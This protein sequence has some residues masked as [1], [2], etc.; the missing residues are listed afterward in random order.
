MDTS[1]TKADDW[2]HTK[3]AWLGIR[4]C[5]YTVGLS[6]LLKGRW[7]Q[8]SL[9]AEHGSRTTLCNDLLARQACWTIE[10]LRQPKEQ[11][12]HCCLWSWISCSLQNIPWMVSHG[13]QGTQLWCAAM[14]PAFIV[15]CYDLILASLNLQK[16]HTASCVIAKSCC[17]TCC[18]AWSSIH[19]YMTTM[20]TLLS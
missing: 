9:I 2:V 17:N 4:C 15:F 6:K 18:C 14:S 7:W 3:E 1:W 19:Q 13:S 10:H 5:E 11:G 20:E 8:E 12:F 16:P